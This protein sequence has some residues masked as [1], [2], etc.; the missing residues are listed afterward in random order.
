MDALLPSFQAVASRNQVSMVLC[1]FRNVTNRMV[2]LRARGEG[3]FFL[4]RVVFPFE[5]M[6]FHCP[7]EG[8]VE[9]INRG[10][11]GR[12][13]HESLAVE[14][15]LA[16]EFDNASHVDWRPARSGKAMSV[17]SNASSIRVEGC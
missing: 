2:I 15:L 16:A 1:S 7:L 14:Q 9:V 3:A 10:A 11:A 8:D 4:E 17:R 6:T 12:E 13:E 5:V